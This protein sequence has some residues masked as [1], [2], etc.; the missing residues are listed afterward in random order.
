[1]LPFFDVF[2]TFVT[3]CGYCRDGFIN[4]ILNVGMRRKEIESRTIIVLL[5]ADDTWLSDFCFDGAS[6]GQSLAKRLRVIGFRQEA[7]CWWSEK[8]CARVALSTLRQRISETGVYQL[9]H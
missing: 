3:L 1:M 5:R 8:S 4:C 6:L 2:M 9:Q 7:G